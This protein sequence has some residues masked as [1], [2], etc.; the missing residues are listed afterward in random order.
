MNRQHRYY[1]PSAWHSYYR[2]P[3]VQYCVLFKTPYRRHYTPV[4]YQLRKTDTETI[5]VRMYIEINGLTIESQTTRSNQSDRYRT[6]RRTRRT[7]NNT[8]RSENRQ[9]TEQ[10]RVHNKSIQ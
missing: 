7:T 6:N 8:T 5:D 4:R 9:T 2:V 3:N 10:Q 1:T